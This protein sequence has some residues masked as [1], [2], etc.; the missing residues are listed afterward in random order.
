MKQEKRKLEM[1]ITSCGMCPFIYHPDD[2]YDPSFCKHDY[3]KF[4]GSTIIEDFHSIKED[5][6]LTKIEE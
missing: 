3:S 6:P 1:T 4:M 5:C 2:V